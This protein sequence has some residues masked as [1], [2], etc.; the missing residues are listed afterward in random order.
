MSTNLLGHSY[1]LRHLG[2]G[3]HAN[4][5]GAGQDRGRHGSRGTP[6]ALGCRSPA[7]RLSHERLARW[8]DEHR[9]VERRRELG[10]TGQHTITVRRPFGKPQARVDDH[11]LEG[12]AGSS[13]TT[14]TLFQLVDHLS[15]HLAIVRLEVHRL[16]RT[17]AMHQDKRR[18][19]IGDHFGQ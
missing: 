12:H 10:Q 1:N 6:V 16:R 4:D 15:D 8:P 2:D 9:A 11:A 7:Q 3:M 17:A 18:A 5:V 14:E 19:R 13:G